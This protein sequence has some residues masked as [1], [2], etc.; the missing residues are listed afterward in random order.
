MSVR[1]TATFLAVVGAGLVTVGVG[2]IYVPAGVI[3]GGVILLAVGV[4]ALRP[5]RGGA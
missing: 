4:E 3:V 5:S 1:L 2:M